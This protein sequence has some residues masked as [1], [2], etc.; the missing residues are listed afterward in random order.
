MSFSAAAQ[1]AARVAGLKQT[2][3]DICV[4]SGCLFCVLY[5]LSVFFSSSA[6]GS[7]GCWPA[8]DQ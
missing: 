4:S 1:A 8:A 3:G 6:G 5:G 2:S 7:S